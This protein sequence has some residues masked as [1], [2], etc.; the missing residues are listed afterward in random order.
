[1][2]QCPIWGDYKYFICPSQYILQ[3]F[4]YCYKPPGKALEY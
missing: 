1:M 2:E 3:L 4:R